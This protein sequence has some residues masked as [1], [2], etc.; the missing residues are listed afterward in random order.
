MR[1]IDVMSPVPACCSPDDT[2]QQAAELMERHGCGCLPVVQEPE[3]RRGVMGVVTDGDVALRRP[4][5]GQDA[6]TLVREVL[7]GEPKCCSPQT[8]LGEIEELMSE[9]RIRRILVVDQSGCCVGMIDQTEPADSEEIWDVREIV[10]EVVGP[11][12]AS[13]A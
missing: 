7:Q 1:A 5:T 11:T 6:A 2:I 9:Q 12:D 10:R 13:A 4:R 8:Q 3:E